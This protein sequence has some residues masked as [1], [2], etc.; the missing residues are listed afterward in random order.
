MF[1]QAK[2]GYAYAQDQLTY[3]LVLQMD[4]IILCVQENVYT[5]FRIS[6]FEYA[7]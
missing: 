1:L 5:Q 3:I 7:S 6:V 2:D 4:F